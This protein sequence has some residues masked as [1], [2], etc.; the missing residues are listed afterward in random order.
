L[1]VQWI[2]AVVLYTVGHSTLAPN[3]FLALLRGH[4]IEHLVDVRRFPGSRRHPHFAAESLA[5]ALAHEGIRYTHEPE[6][7]GRRS[8]AAN[9]PNTAWRAAGFRAYA[10]YMA[11][12]AF[13]AALERL[14]DH[15]GEAAT[16]IMCAEA[17]PWR[18]HRQLIADALVAREHE[19]RHITSMTRA[20]PHRLNPDARVSEQ[21]TI[22]YPGSSEQPSLL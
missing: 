9:S 19:V 1:L 8:A 22:T 16:A 3:E 12:P 6:L 18:C 4:G 10:D 21:R 20:D 14:L 15:A 5:R 11:T 7:G 13:Q 2:R 17:V